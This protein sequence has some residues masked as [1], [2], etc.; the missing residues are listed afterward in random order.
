MRSFRSQLNN[1]IRARR[2]CHICSLLSAICSLFLASQAFAI[3]NKKPSVDAGFFGDPFW[4]EHVH[5]ADRMDF[6]DIDLSGRDSSDWDFWS[7][8]KTYYYEP[9]FFDDNDWADKD[10]FYLGESFPDFR[11]WETF[12]L[13]DSHPVMSLPMPRSNA[14][15]S[16]DRDAEVERQIE[17]LL[18]ADTHTGSRTG[19]QEFKTDAG[20][21]AAAANARV[22]EDTRRP[23]GCP[24]D[25]DAECEIWK[26][27][28]HVIET[29]VNK[30]RKISEEN[31]EPL[32]LLARSGIEIS[33]DAL[34][35]Q[36]LVKRYRMLMSS[37]HACCANGMAYRLKRA[38]ASDGLVYKFIVDDGN[39]YLFSERCLMT[40]DDDLDRIFP[41]TQTAEVMADVRNTC[42]CRGREWFSSLLAPFNQVYEAAPEFKSQPFSYT[43]VDGLQ[44]R[45]TVS[46]NKDVQ[47]VLNQLDACP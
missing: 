4:D 29:V 44:R 19:K 20:I 10:T 7:R 26:R 46:I 41:D 47:A 43:Y 11:G 31:I 2:G 45:I 22:A 37:A 9:D 6:R 3:V 21:A 27:K 17:E 28:P 16:M 36:P 23:D 30:P 38:G 35:A 14:P 8:G 13:S 5:H 39:F 24:L 12:S 18:K 33:S 15:V 40:S 42:L 25:T 32:M 1:N 34:D